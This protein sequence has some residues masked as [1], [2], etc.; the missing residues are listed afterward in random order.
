[1][2]NTTDYK[3]ILKNE[4]A[5]RIDRN[6]KYSVRAFAKSLEVDSGALSRILSGKQIP[7]AKVVNKILENMLFEPSER[8][9]LLLSIKL[10]QQNRNLT[11]RNQFQKEERPVTTGLFKSLDI[12]V[13]RVMGEWFH[14]AIMELTFVKG[15]SSSPKWISSKLAISETEACLAI[16]RLKRLELIKED[17][18]KT[19]KKTDQFLDTK[20]KHLTTPALRKNQKQFL[21]K[22][23]ESLENDSIHERSMTS[24]TMAI[25][26]SRIE[27]AKKVINEFNQKMSTFLESGE[28]TRVY[29][30]SIALYPL[31]K[32]KNNKRILTQEKK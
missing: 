32:N 18:N 23:I 12:D 6:S 8:E 9:E 29:N 2:E 4:L 15:F 21:E 27:E 13:F 31:Q 16:D 14:S 3:I 11:R 20:D 24:M 19:L 30:L 1:M 28:Q 22:A 25:D 10:T 26:E 7:S 5:K 17:E